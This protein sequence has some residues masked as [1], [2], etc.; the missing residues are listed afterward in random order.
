QAPSGGSR[1]KKVTFARQSPM[2]EVPEELRKKAKEMMEEIDWDTRLLE[3]QLEKEKD[4]EERK[5]LQREIEEKRQQY[6]SIVDR[7]GW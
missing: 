2:V 4:K 6:R 5:R 7:F 1:S 3:G